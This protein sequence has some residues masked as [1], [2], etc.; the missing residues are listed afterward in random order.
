MQTKMPVSEQFETALN[1]ILDLFQE[2]VG[3]NKTHICQG[4]M[5]AFEATCTEVIEKLTV[6]P[7]EEALLTTQIKS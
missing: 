2:R 6:E 4:D 1:N 7:D 5:S 3:I